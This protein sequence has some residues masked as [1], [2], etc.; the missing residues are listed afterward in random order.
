MNVE[1]ILIENSHTTSS[2][3]MNMILILRPIFI[4]VLL[5]DLQEFSSDL[6]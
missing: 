4:V 1:L 5:F 3:A 6:S 2:T